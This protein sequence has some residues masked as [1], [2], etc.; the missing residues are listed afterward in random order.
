MTENQ[1]HERIKVFRGFNRFYT[2]QI[3]LLNQGLLKT[4]FSLTQARILFEIAQRDNSSMVDLCNE[5]SIDP[6]YLSR[7]IG[8]FERDGLVQKITSRSDSRQRL[9]KLK[10]KG[11]EAFTLLDTR[12]TEEAETL[13]KRL[14]KK[15]QERLLNSMKI[16]KEIL[17]DKPASSAPYI[18]RPYRAGDIG[19]ITHRHGALYAEEYGF[20]I[21]FESLVAG[22]LVDFIDQ[23]DPKTENIW[24]AEQDGKKIGSVMIVDA[25][26]GVAQLRLLLVE[27][28]ARRQGIGKFLIDHCINFSKFNGYKKIK[29]WTQSILSEARSL[30]IKAGFKIIEKK[31]HTSFGHNLTAETW[32][33]IL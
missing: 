31:S 25:G 24:I 27:P 30:Y 33:L 2:K 4:R 26:E 17:E 19:W 8:A 6:G 14:S 32:E 3:G 29:L 13:L 1:M 15:K 22:I 5:L 18:L 10:D 20:D 7:I 23:H 9:L 12:S 16:I 11:K 21:T 28:E